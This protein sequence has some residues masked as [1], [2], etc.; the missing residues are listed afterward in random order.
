[1]LS[2]QLKHTTLISTEKLKL[3]V[4]YYFSNLKNFLTTRKILFTIEYQLTIKGN[5]KVAYM[6]EW[7]P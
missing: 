3:T 7:G 4:F 2:N 5:F 1:M 6:S